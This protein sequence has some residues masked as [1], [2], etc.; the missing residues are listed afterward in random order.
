MSDVYIV[1]E[2]IIRKI[3]NYLPNCT[4]LD[5]IFYQKFNVLNRNKRLLVEKLYTNMKKNKIR[6]G[7]TSPW[8]CHCYKWEVGNIGYRI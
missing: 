3:N 6:D 5:Q 4:K 1:I 8:V 7:H 2:K